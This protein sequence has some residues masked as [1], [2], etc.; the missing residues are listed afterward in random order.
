MA[1]IDRVKNILVTPKSEWL[2][3]AGESPSVQSLFVGYI[4]V[5]AAIGPIAIALRFGLF[6]AGI[7]VALISYAIGLAMV[8]LLAWIIDAPAARKLSSG[9]CNSSR[10]RSPRHGWPGSSTC[11]PS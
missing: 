8:Y 10:I 4:M 7:G 9:R 3:I 5:L 2:A 11:F 1:L 6:G